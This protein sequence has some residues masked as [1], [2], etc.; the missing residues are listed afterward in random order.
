M[1][2]YHANQTFSLC[3]NLFAQERAVRQRSCWPSANMALLN[4][5]A[6]QSICQ[7]HCKWHYTGSHLSKQQTRAQEPALPGS[8]AKSTSNKLHQTSASC[9]DWGH[10]TTTIQRQMCKLLSRTRHSSQRFVL[11]QHCVSKYH[12]AGLVNSQVC[13]LQTEPDA[14]ANRD[15]TGDSGSV[16][17]ACARNSRHIPSPWHWRYSIYSRTPCSLLGLSCSSHPL[18]H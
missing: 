18:S 11:T 2:G 5:F 3:M 12:S 13:A 17:P 4:P 14:P 15:E 6:R 10:K 1:K 7:S 9:S 16:E 8:C